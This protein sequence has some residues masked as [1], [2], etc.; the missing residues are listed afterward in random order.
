MLNSLFAR[1]AGVF[2]RASEPDIENDFDPDDE[3]WDDELRVCYPD[4][5]D[6]LSQGEMDE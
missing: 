3:D 4:E 2:C 1:I 5:F 6:P